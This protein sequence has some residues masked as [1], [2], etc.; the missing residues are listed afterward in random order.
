MNIVIT[1]YVIIL[2]A[3]IL[4]TYFLKFILEHCTKGKY[5]IR[6][7]LFTIGILLLLSFLIINSLYTLGHNINFADI[8]FILIIVIAFRCSIYKKNT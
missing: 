1:T 5:S 6:V 3:L 7:F 4:I 8:I 2:V